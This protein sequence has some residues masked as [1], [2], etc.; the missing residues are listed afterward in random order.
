VKKKEPMKN[1]L[2]KP[3]PNVI[4]ENEQGRGVKRTTKKT[5]RKKERR[6]T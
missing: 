2:I 4:T 6:Y 3:R 1:Q 5:A